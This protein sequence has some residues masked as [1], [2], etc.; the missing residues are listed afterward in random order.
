MPPTSAS[1]PSPEYLETS[2]TP[3]LPPSSPTD[4]RKLLIL[5]LNGTLLLRSSRRAGHR[6]QTRPVV[7]A[8]YPRP[9]LRAFVN[10]IFHTETLKWLDTMVWSSA[11]PHSVADM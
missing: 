6:S 5:D 10:Y 7:R 3:S 1:S 4:Q 11:Q 9:Y 2:Q 8:V